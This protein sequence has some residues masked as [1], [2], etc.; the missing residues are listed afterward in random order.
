MNIDFIRNKTEQ[1]KLNQE[2]R[3]SDKETITTILALDKEY[4]IKSKEC[5]DMRHKKNLLSKNYKNITANDSSL[6]KEI[7]D[8]QLKLDTLTPSLNADNIKHL[9]L[10][11]ETYKKLN[12]HI[13]QYI[14]DLEKQ[15]SVLIEQRDKLI[16]T[17]GNMLIPEANIAANED[18]NKIVIIKDQEP[19]VNNYPL[20]HIDILEKFKLVDYNNGIKI[21]GNRGYFLTGFMVK[22]N[23]ALMSYATNFLEEHGYT[24]MDTP[25]FIL[26]PQISKVS[27]LEDFEDTL[28]KLESQDKYLIATSE[29]PLTSYF[30]NTHYNNKQSNTEGKLPIKFGGISTCF[31][32]ETGAHNRNTRGIFRVHQFSKVEQFVITD[33]TSSKDMFNEMIDLSAKF[34]DSL[35]ISY[36]IINIASGA[37][38]NSA[39]IKYD[40]EGW[41]PGSGEYLE[42]VSCT[43]TTNYFSSRIGCT[44][45][46]GPDKEYVHML[47]CTLCANTR[48]ICCIVET[49]QT[50]HGFIIPTVLRPYLGGLT[51][52]TYENK[53]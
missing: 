18:D 30:S 15:K 21:A 3:F 33:K 12:T 19:V 5:D 4:L 1:V 35:G 38:N 52:Y 26:K 14:L 36:R 37:L 53:K 7:T 42:L 49:M 39:A 31:R 29:Q 8:L 34:Y 17:V 46:N 13:D 28:Y 2:Q 45:Q 50:E 6:N 20:S 43:N 9:K 24:L 32:K 23:L 10:T 25:Q 22:F 41:F 11:I 27:Q 40:L 51:E 16:Y 48:T 47:N 44:Y